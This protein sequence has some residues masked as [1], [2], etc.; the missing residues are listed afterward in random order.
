MTK[1]AFAISRVEAQRWRCSFT[2]FQISK[3]KLQGRWDAEKQMDAFG[4]GFCELFR[5]REEGDE[6][7]EEVLDLK[8]EI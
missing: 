2:K 8:F 1:T 4:K 3:F 5:D 7:G 6:R